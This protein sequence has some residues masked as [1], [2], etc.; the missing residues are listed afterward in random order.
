MPLHTPHVPPPTLHPLPYTGVSLAGA[1]FAETQFPG[2]YDDHYIY[3]G[4]PDVDYFLTHSLSTFRIPFRWER[5]QPALHAPLDPTELA[6]LTSLVTYATSR[7]AHIILDPHNYCRYR[8]QPPHKFESATTGLLGHDV[9]SSALADLWTRLATHFLP[10]PR[11]IH[12]LMNE[13]AHLSTDTWLSAANHAIAALRSTSYSGPIL[14]SGNRFTGAWTWFESDKW[15]RS[16][17]SAMLDLIDPADNLIIEVHQYFDEDGS[18]T[19][20]HLH[21]NDP[22]LPLQRLAPF[23]DW[24]RTHRKKAFLGEFGIPHTTFGPS[25]NFLGD[26]A[27]T[28][29]LT[30]L[31]SHPEIYTGWAWWAAGPW[32]PDDYLF[33]LNPSPESPT[34]PRPALTHL[35]RFARTPSPG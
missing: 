22:F 25:A 16:N 20:D 19:H 5:L 30:H 1:E 15:G 9:P 8:P 24:A 12:S 7:G 17:A 4:P 2:I 27:L 14:V 6:R 34:I 33:T 10:N 11:V 29:L 13:P 21:H 18:G 23:T 3:P 32:W 28:H 31:H 26:Q 35:S